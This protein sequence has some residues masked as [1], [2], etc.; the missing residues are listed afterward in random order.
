MSYD[1]FLV[2]PKPGEDIR[3]L[4]YR[5]APEQEVAIDDARKALIQTIIAKLRE[6]T[7]TFELFESKSVVELTETKNNTGLQIIFYADSAAISVPYW[8]EKNDRNVLDQ[9]EQYLA[10]LD[11]V[12]GFVAFDPQTETIL[13]RENNFAI[14]SSRYGDGVSALKHVMNERKPWWK[15]W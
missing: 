1:I 9:M 12:G 4:A 15:F 3:E 5:D 11:E 6:V 2:Q 10:I 13:S 14:S 7:P 8:H